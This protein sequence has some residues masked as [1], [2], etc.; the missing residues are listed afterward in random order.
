MPPIQ[1]GKVKTKKQKQRKEIDHARRL[2]P[3]CSARTVL[4][5]ILE[6]TLAATAFEKFPVTF[7]R[8]RF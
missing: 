2:R 7:S 4:A 3:G 5:T 8:F 6:L 1:K